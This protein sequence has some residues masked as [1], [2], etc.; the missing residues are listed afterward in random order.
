MSKLKVGIL[1]VQSVF[2][3]VDT[4]CSTEVRLFAELRNCEC[5]SVSLKIQTVTENAKRANL[6]QALEAAQHGVEI[7]IVVCGDAF[8]DLDVLSMF[9][10]GGI[11]EKLFEITR[12]TADD[13]VLVKDW[14]RFVKDKFAGG[15]YARADTR[16][17]LWQIDGVFGWVLLHSEGSVAAARLDNQTQTEDM[18][19]N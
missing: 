6:G 7:G 4:N 12:G 3:N 13:L 8:C 11:V 1:V 17:G 2:A 15:K 5:P 9:R 14:D 18:A 16:V 19:V 10:E